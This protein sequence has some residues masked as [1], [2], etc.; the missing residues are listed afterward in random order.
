[1]LSGAALHR[2]ATEADRVKSGPLIDSENAV[3]AMANTGVRSSVVR[4]PPTVHSA[5]DH[6]G[7]MPTLIAMARKNGVSVYVG[8]G[9]NRWP[10][11]HTFDA[12]R[13]SRLA[14]GKAPAGSRLHG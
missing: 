3:I 8:D 14:L 11:V 4:L 5:L 9:S 2:V 12:A 7:F 6:H 13:L 10:A 1:M